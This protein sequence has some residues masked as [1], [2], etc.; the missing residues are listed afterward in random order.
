MTA[1]IF[2]DVLGPVMRG[3]SSSHVAG[4][5]RIAGLVR[6]AAGG[7]PRKVTVTFDPDGS[8]A[9]SHDGHGTD[10][11]FAC[12]IMGIS[13]T[14]PRVNDWRS[15]LAERGIEL[16]YRI[17][18]FGAEHPNHY[19][20][21]VLT[22]SGRNLMIDAVSVGGG[23]VELIGINGCRVSVRGDR[24]ETVELPGTGEIFRFT[25]VMPVP[26]SDA[27]LPFT[28]AQE[29]LTYNSGR[30][31]ALWELALV[32]ESRRCGLGEDEVYALMNR[33]YA[34]MSDSLDAGLSGTEYEDRIL[35]MQS[36]LM[37]QNAARLVPGD[38]VN[39]AIRYISAIMENKSAMGV[40][41]A[42]P[43]AGS[44]GCLPGTLMALRDVLGLD[45]DC[46]V[47]G[48]LA[49][50]LIGVF[51]AGQATFAAEAA[52]CQVEC[53][54]GSGMAAAAV[55]QMMGGS[56]RECIDA[57]SFALQGITGL[58]C[59]PVANRVEVPCLNKN[60]LGGMN[61]I[62]S[63]NVI[64][65]GYDKVIPLD[66]TIRAIYDIGTKLPQELRCTYGGLGRTPASNAIRQK[67]EKY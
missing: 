54:A 31:L 25:P 23:A 47:K 21:D 67:L 7:D 61:A 51:F 39:T 59:D 35:P 65:A 1:D 46:V 15:L 49:A 58:A 32:F 28:T 55:C 9:E 12:G 43:T 33:L 37:K 13:I 42:A 45:E 27:E 16:E 10:M 8:L 60:I 66:E 53:G 48:L 20:I 19:R 63:A 4:G 3:P 17:E 26:S 22:C 18:A 29:M 2:N 41:A 24:D 36:H 64:L 50:G 62:S 30:E 14:D 6:Q 5:S 38:V 44:A 52:G 56:A 11:G 57:A 40:F 34:V